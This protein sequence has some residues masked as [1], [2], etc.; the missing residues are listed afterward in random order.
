[1]VDGRPVQCF[2][3]RWRKRDFHDKQV[4]IG[5]PASQTY[6]EVLIFVLAVELWCT[7]AAP[8]EIFG[9]NV[10]ALQSALTLKGRGE[11]LRLF[12][13]LAVLRSARSLDLR[14]AHLPSES[15]TVADA[16]SRQ[17]GPPSDRLP[18]PYGP[19]DGV[20]LV[21]PVRPPALWALLS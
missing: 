8:V 3:C 2:S 13:A 6:F 10:A 1:M 16:L 12:L 17:H 9:D 18:W 11:Q 4:E 21:A 15:N 7:D 5:Q 14:V 20:E 19:G